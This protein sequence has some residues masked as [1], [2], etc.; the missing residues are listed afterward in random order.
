MSFSNDD[1]DL[2]EN[3]KKT[4]AAREVSVHAIYGRS[5]RSYKYDNHFFFSF[6]LN[7][8][9]VLKISTQEKTLSTFDSL[10]V[11]ESAQQ[12]L[13]T[14]KFVLRFIRFKSKNAITFQ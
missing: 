4:I 3:V 5:K 12:N 9:A 8:D 10:S 1:D 11:L 7:F 13:K 14:L 6:P 2:H